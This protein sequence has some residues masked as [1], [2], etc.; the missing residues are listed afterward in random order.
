[1]ESVLL[2]KPQQSLKQLYDSA[3]LLAHESPDNINFASLLS[4]V[5]Q[6]VS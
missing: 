3:V 5:S 6:Y 4:P 2:G 1:M